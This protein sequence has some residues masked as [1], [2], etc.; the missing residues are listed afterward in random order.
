MAEA[1]GPSGAREG[2]V[3]ACEAD[4]GAL[5]AALI[6]RLHA[7]TLRAAD[8]PVERRR[9]CVGHL[10]EEGLTAAETAR[11]MGIGE[12]TVRRDRAALRRE[13]GLEPGRTLGDELLGE[14]E[15][16]VSTSNARLTRLSQDP[17][18]PA[19]VRLHAEEARVRNYHRLIEMAH[20]LR[21]VESGTGRLSEARMGS[22]AEMVGLGDP[23]G[24]LKG[25]R[26]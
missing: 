22:L 10:C 8:L 18:T 5:S 2:D 4:G 1:Q 12:R 24:L 23:L 7:G 9:A 14:F 20:R 26:E 25:G 21:Y 6:E 11:L 13:A 3:V 19:Y 16:V 15:R 17:R